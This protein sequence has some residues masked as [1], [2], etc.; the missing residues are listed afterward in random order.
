MATQRL[1]GPGKLIPSNQ[2]YKHLI[3]NQNINLQVC[4]RKLTA[5]QTR[6]FVSACQHIL[7]PV[8]KKAWEIKLRTG[9]CQRSIKLEESELGDFNEKIVMQLLLPKVP[10][11]P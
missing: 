8:G 2:I 10:S 5:K 3:I 9:G 6:I 11:P 1:T 7:F 4:M